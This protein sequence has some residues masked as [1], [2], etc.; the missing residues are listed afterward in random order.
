[1]NSK[2]ELEIAIEKLEKTRSNLEKIKL[3][4]M[5]TNRKLLSMVSND[6]MYYISSSNISSDDLKVTL[7][8]EE[9]EFLKNKKKVLNTN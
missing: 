3:E 2:S 7:V 9:T 8:F 1:M 5:D 6:K 4:S